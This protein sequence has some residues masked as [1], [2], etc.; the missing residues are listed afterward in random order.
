MKIGGKIKRMVRKIIKTFFFSICCW[1]VFVFSFVSSA[2]VSPID[3]KNKQLCY[4]KDKYIHKNSYDYNSRNFAFYRN[5]TFSDNINSVI[6]LRR[7]GLSKSPWELK[8][9]QVNAGLFSRNQ[10]VI[11]WLKYDTSQKNNLNQ[12]CKTINKECIF[13][14]VYRGDINPIIETTGSQSLS[15]KYDGQLKVSIYDGRN[16]ILKF[17]TDCSE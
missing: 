15:F 11:H 2:K 14:V 4:I 6:I 7:V 5:K 1:A 13:K 17:P 12:L 8:G 9:V 3:E 10:S 16:N